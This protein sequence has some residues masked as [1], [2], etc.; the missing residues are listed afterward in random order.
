MMVT[1]ALS[2]SGL[3]IQTQPSTTATAGVAFTQQPVVRIEDQFG[4]LR[5]SDTTTVVTAS[6]SA[7]SGALQGSTN[8]TALNGIVSFNNLSHNVATNISIQF[9]SGALSGATSSAIAVSPATATRLTIQTQPS[10]TATAGAI[11]SQQ[12]VVRVE[13]G[14][15]N[16]RTADNTTV[17]SAGRN[18]GSAT[19]Q[20]TTNLTAS[21]GL[22]TFAN[23]NYT[24]AE[25]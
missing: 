13:D 8:Q 11:F 19:L 10:S 4:N 14:F 5:S 18:L 3:T 7:G 24:L 15:G 9:S 12:P 17:V 21:G 2:A 23:L 6:R 22:V 16:L 25:T 1:S 20:G